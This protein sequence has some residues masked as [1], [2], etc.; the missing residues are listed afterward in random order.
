MPS[1]SGS[2]EQYY[3]MDRQIGGATS[4]VDEYNAFDYAS[5]ASEKVVHVDT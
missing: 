1:M 3:E 4:E 5:V 2:S